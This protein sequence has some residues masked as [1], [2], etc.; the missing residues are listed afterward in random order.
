[1]QA[2][3]EYVEQQTAKATAKTSPKRPVAD[4]ELGPRPT[5][6]LAEAGI[7][8]VGQLLEKLAEGEEAALAVEGFGR[9]ALIDAK[10]K[11]R[12]LGYE[13]PGVEEAA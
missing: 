10:K 12:A 8:E 6:A 7:T 9:K 3:Q 2:R 5:R 1:M 13:V 4:L 11:L